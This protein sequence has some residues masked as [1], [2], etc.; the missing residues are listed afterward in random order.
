[1]CANSSSQNAC[2]RSASLGRHW[3][4]ARACRECPSRAGSGGRPSGC[5]PTSSGCRETMAASGKSDS[6]AMSAPVSHSASRQPMTA[7][8]A[9]P[10]S[11][12]SPSPR[13]LPF[14]ATAVANALR[15]TNQ[16]AMTVCPPRFWMLIN[17]VRATTSAT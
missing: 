14:T 2:V 8:S 10:S 9:A 16:L 12:H 13:R 4:S 17:A 15:C 11:G 7:M 5:S 1:M 6:S 3:C